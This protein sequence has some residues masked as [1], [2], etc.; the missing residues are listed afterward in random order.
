LQLGI[1]QHVLDEHA[2]ELDQLLIERNWLVHKGLTEI[3]FASREECENLVARLDD[4]E[5]RV[6]RQIDFLRPIVNRIGEF[7]KFF[8]SDDVQERIRE[9]LRGPE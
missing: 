2:K 9:M 3:D 5:R 7:I 8:D 4:Q 6:I 1:P